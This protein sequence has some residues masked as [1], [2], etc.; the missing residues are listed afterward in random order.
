V[1]I[2][3]HSPV[4]DGAARGSLGAADVW[5]AIGVRFRCPGLR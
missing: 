4:S 2:Q 3:L 5:V 1:V